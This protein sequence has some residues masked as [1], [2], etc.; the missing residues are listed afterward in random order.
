MRSLFIPANLIAKCYALVE[1][2]HA[3]SGFRGLPGLIRTEENLLPLGAIPYAV[4]QQSALARGRRLR[5]ACWFAAVILAVAAGLTSI[6]WL[7]AGLPLV[8]IIDWRIRAAMR[9]R[10][11]FLA[12]TLL[13]LETLTNNF[14]GWGDAYPAERDS[15]VGLLA[16]PPGSPRH[17]WLEFY[18]PRIRTMDPVVLKDFAPAG[19]AK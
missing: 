17:T 10:W 15:A 2:T 3:S 12:S 5:I 16:D 13:A 7:L 11:M 19:K 4:E 8:A 1:L 9:K 6:W 14:A 18:L